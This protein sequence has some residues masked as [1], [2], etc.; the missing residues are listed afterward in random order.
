[1]EASEG[2][3]KLSIDYISLTS[4]PTL[5]E[6]IHVVCASDP[7]FLLPLCV[8]LTSLVDNFSR[9]RPLG[10]HIIADQLSKEDRAKVANAIS[11]SKEDR[12]IEIIWYEFD[13]SWVKN[14]PA[15]HRI[16]S[17]AYSRLYAPLLLSKDIKRIIY[18]DCDIVILADISELW[19]STKGDSLLYAAHNIGMPYVSS[20]GGVFNYRDLGI[21]SNTKYFNT[22]VMVINL[23]RWR[24]EDV[25]K[26]VIDYLVRWGEKV[27][28]Q[29]QG[30]LNAIAYDQWEEIDPRWNQTWSALFPELWRNLGIQKSMWLETRDRPFIIHFSGGEKPWQPGHRG[31]R[32][33]FYYKY[34]D[35]T[36]FKDAVRNRPVLESIIGFR[37]YYRLWRLRH[38]L[39]LKSNPVFFWA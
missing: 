34:M 37:W 19:D 25:T 17:S 31:P 30:G 6:T 3:C 11:S 4:M 7:G 33:S 28:A 24:R 15:N 1:M 16:T 35:Q 8:M 14:I 26:P 27:F 36:I 20:I 5:H 23:E 32:Y 2:D 13:P 18:L 39:L 38:L 29:D 10:I 12:N 9:E 22:G 21:P